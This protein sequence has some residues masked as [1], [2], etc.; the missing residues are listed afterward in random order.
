MAG[1]VTL[2]RLD[3]I[4]RVGLA[5]AVGCMLQ[6]WWLDGFRYGFFLTVLCTLLHIVT[7]RL[8]DSR[9]AE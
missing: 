1:R 5:A 3:L 2:S 9:A 4:A 8:V 6:P 7:S